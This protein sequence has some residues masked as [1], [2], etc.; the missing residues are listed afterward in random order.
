MR[1]ARDR[2]RESLALND[3]KAS[4]RR[5]RVHLA[6][7]L[8]PLILGIIAME[9]STKGF[10]E[11]DN[12]LKTV[13]VL[14]SKGNSFEDFC[15]KRELLKGIY[16]KGWDTPSPVQES[17]IP[18]AL[19]GR[20][21][22]ARA[23]NGTGK[24]GAYLLPILEKIE[25]K[26][27]HLQALILVPTRELALQTSQ[28]AREISKY[29]GIN[30]MVT[31]GGT[32]LVED[33]VRLNGAVHLLIA[34]PGR[35]LDFL[36]R[37]IINMEKCNTLVLDEADKLLSAGFHEMIDDVIKTLPEDRQIMLY[38]A[39]F[40]VSVQSFTMKHLKNAYEIN[41][42]D[43][44]TLK[45]IT[46]YY[47]YVQEKH[48]VHCLN[49]LF[50]KL[51]INQAIIFCNTAQRVE[52]L[53][54]KVTEL[55]YSY[56]PIMEFAAR[57]T[58]LT[59]EIGLE[60]EFALAE[61]CLKY[62]RLCSDLPRICQKSEI[63]SFAAHSKLIAIGFKD[64]SIRILD[65]LG[66]SVQNG[67]Y[68]KHF[69]AVNCLTVSE[70]GNYIMSCGND[71]FAIIY[72][73]GEPGRSECVNLRHVTK[74]VALSPAYGNVRKFVIA[75][76]KLVLFSKG[77]LTRFKTEELYSSPGL[78]RNLK[79]RRSLLIWSDDQAVRVYDL[80]K[81]SLI[82]Y[83][84]LVKDDQEFLVGRF[85]C[86]LFWHS[87]DCFLMGCG[88]TLNVCHIKR[89][90]PP[91]FDARWSSAMSV[92]R[93]SDTSSQ[94]TSISSS[95]NIPSRT[96]FSVRITSQINLPDA[97]ICGIASHQTY[98][99]LLICPIQS[100]EDA[101]L[102]GS[103]TMQL[104]Q[105]LVVDM[106]DLGDNNPNPSTTGSLLSLPFS[107]YEEVAREEIMLNFNTNHRFQDLGLASIPGEDTHFIFSPVDV[108]CAQVP[109]A[110]DR[111]DWYLEQGLP[112]RALQIANENASDLVKH[113]VKA[114]GSQ[115]ME[116]LI[117]DK[118]FVGAAALCPHILKDMKSWEDQ[119]YRFLH[120]GQLQLLVPYLPV[121][122]IRLS[123]AVYET[124]LLDLMS[125]SPEGFLAKLKD[126]PPNSGLYPVNSLISALQEKTSSVSPI[127][128]KCV[129]A[130]EN[131]DMCALWNALIIL[132][133]YSSCP[134]KG[135]E[136]SIQL[137]NHSMF[138]L[139]RLRL[140]GADGSRFGAVVR[141]NL[142]ALFEMDVQKT[143]SLLLECMR[144]FPVDFV[145][146]EL[147]ANPILLYQ[148]LDAVYIRHPRLA[149]QHIPRMVKLYATY[150]RDKLLH[151]L[152]S[153]DGYPLNE[154]LEL[155][156]RLNYVSETVYLLTRVGRR[157]DALK[158]L[159]EKGADDVTVVGDLSL[160]AEQRQA[161]V[162]A[163]AIAYCLEEDSSS[164]PYYE[165]NERRNR[166]SHSATSRRR[167]REP[168]LSTGLGA[169]PSSE[170]VTLRTPCE[171]DSSQGSA[172]EEE[173]KAEEGKRAAEG[174][175]E[176]GE[177]WKQVVLFAADKPGFICALLKHASTECI[178]PRL[179]L[180]KIAPNTEIPN[181]KQSLITLLHNTQMQIELR[182][183]CQ[184]ILLKDSY[185]KFSC[186]TAAQSRGIR[187]SPIGL[188]G[189]NFCRVCRQ[190]LLTE[191]CLAK[192]TSVS[193]GD[194]STS[195]VR[196]TGLH[197]PALMVFRCSHGYHQKCLSGFG[198]MVAC[199]V[200]VQERLIT[201]A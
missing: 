102:T 105:I 95:I 54:K 36:N 22:L 60:A 82:N 9:K 2:R 117:N 167:P 64:G 189:H 32:N 76:S 161:Q 181:L 74:C 147:D 160:S 116:Q 150:A 145:V 185:D 21:I 125:A 112:H 1:L 58:E 53:A 84:P 90:T 122:S 26:V 153:T 71:G 162:A 81:R 69:T 75:D 66:N 34:T 108:I 155:C 119:V 170:D 83:I 49:T 14:S 70:D 143:I 192:T 6:T 128:N 89:H 86:H 7:R 138:D 193:T 140:P 96:T 72:D 94:I 35:T 201:A 52:L 184:R 57:G 20:D 141:Q 47:A 179:L 5:Y 104:P 136:L 3:V 11:K 39:T 165:Y 146:R 135:L 158:L 97:L 151:F 106:G 99:L 173:E 168:Y 190:P 80:R 13:D 159:M 187:V 134:E 25:P 124:V 126:W 100:D 169:S 61:P 114:L 183:N 137:R 46:Q 10:P 17:S 110:D 55:G 129:V 163:K 16:E 73:L 30:V 171:T 87:D 178:D 115:Y 154:A 131:P 109:S 67:F 92:D 8:S 197:Q 28:I 172:Y 56:C 27:D 51:Q 188:S 59:E 42:M 121:T 43:E 37:S 195:E 200:C 133:E 79:W 166:L 101:L 182:R 93:D 48:K 23:K 91:D 177:L 4:N 45:G 180:Q 50:S 132:Y 103:S 139:L 130:K 196:A 111:V 199:P 127:A 164:V 191:G 194:S 149:Q 18:V 12:R 38:S 77:A 68:K 198:K 157:R 120:L 15:L 152:R 175:A 44:L 176:S 142:I 65:H 40:P 78:I 85:P 24:T 41:L 186:L 148:Y 88:K 123:P 98:V 19:T 29:L 107:S 118:D 156:Q 174:S 63:A 113:S 144:E 33:L 62:H 31:T